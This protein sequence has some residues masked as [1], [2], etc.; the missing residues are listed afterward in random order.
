VVICNKTLVTRNARSFEIDF[1]IIAEHYVFVIDEKSWR[2]RIHGSDQVWVRED[3]SSERSPLSKAD[4]V[5]KVLAGELRAKIPGLQSITEHFVQGAVLLSASNE[6]PRIK[7]PRANSQVFLIDTVV[8]QLTKLDAASNHQSIRHLAQ[9]IESSLLDLSDRPKF[10]KRIDQYQIE[11]IVGETQ[12]S[13]TARAIHDL[14]GLRTLTVYKVASVSE[15]TRS[16]YEREFRAIRSLHS[17]GHVPEVLDPFNWS[18]DFWVVPSVPPPGK[19]LASLKFP[20]DV[21]GLSE[22]L[23]GAAM[24]FTALEAI[25]ARGVIHRALS[26]DNVYIEMAHREPRKVVLAGFQSARLENQSS[27][28]PQLDELM[29]VDPYAARAGHQS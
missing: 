13:Y 20:E 12:G 28:A 29:A 18:D 15:D 27:I 19:A 21:N 14:A 5:A 23:A 25:H 26:P 4:Y 10:A 2:G 6:R 17:T 3:G 9:S 7:D 22:E 11:E 24:A 8:G 1:L 16:R